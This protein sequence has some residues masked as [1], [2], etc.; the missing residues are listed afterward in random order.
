MSRSDAQIAAQLEEFVERLDAGGVLGGSFSPDST[1][2]KLTMRHGM[3]APWQSLDAHDDQNA[4]GSSAGIKP[5]AP[6][7]TQAG[8]DGKPESQTETAFDY[9]R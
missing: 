4:K 6:E 1:G 5:I 7:Q 3:K 2:Q 8:S 9:G